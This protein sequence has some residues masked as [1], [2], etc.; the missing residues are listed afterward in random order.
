VPLAELEAIARSEFRR[1]QP[2][3]KYGRVQR[4][5]INN[6]CARLIANWKVL[7]QFLDSKGY[8]RDLK[9]GGPSGFV[10]LA[11]ISAPD[12]S[13]KDL[14]NVLMQFGS[15]SRNKSGRLRLRSKVFM[16]TTPAGGVVAFEPHLQFLIDA[17]RVIED[18]LQI[19]V[20]RN[21]GPKRYWR[22][23][24]NLWVPSEH[25]EEFLAFS[26]R[27]AMVFMEEIEDWLDQHEIESRD[28]RTKKLSR[29]G[30]GLYAIC[31]R[32]TSQAV[33]ATAGSRGLIGNSRDTSLPQI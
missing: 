2:T 22:T 23:V 26:K 20:A 24:D 1:N 25:A 12:V 32:S 15:V 18:Q 33:T 31:E 28:R 19:P 7:P 10:D 11:K 5:S 29:L 30:V 13:P 9:V 16:C 3:K 27:V 6:H 14:L 8:P 17:A 4:V 21:R